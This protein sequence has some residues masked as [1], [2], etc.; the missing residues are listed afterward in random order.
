MRMV[1]P[2]LPLGIAAMT[3]ATDTRLTYARIQAVVDGGVSDEKLHPRL[4]DRTIGT[5]H[6]VIPAL[7]LRHQSSAA[8]SSPQPPS[9]PPHRLVQRS[10]WA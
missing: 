2:V 10:A 1:V 7:T 9:T 8:D 4:C 5:R 6:S 3:N